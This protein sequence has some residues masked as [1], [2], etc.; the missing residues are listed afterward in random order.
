[1]ENS[2]N[3]SFSEVYDIITHFDGNLYSKISPNFI[4]MVK[5]NK[6]DSYIANINYSI[7]INEQNLLKETRVILSLI[8]RDY[9]CSKEKRQE[10]IYKDNIELKTH[11]EEMRKKY[12]VDYVFKSR[13]KVEEPQQMEMVEYKESILMKIIKRIFHKNQ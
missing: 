1:M 9:I 3:Q 8:Y 6:D 10:L 2:I 12:N 13:K 4:E 5:Q 7:N 11:E